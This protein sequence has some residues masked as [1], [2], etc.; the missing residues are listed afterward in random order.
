MQE[1]GRIEFIGV[2]VGDE[3][4]GGYLAG[5]RCGGFEE[6]IS[7]SGVENFTIMI[8]PQS[9]TTS[10]VS[11]SSPFRIN[12][13]SPRAHHTRISILILSSSFSSR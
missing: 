8:I 10:L 9:P 4:F 13:T 3:D 2:G 12:G 1:G 7:A 5:G 11:P 6:G